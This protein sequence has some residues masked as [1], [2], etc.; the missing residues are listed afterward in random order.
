MFFLELLDPSFRR[1][2]RGGIESAQYKELG[3][4]VAHVQL[5]QIKDRW[6]WTLS[7]NGEFSVKSVRNL[8]DDS[9]LSS[10][11]PPTR[12]V[13][14]IRIKINVFAWKVQKDKL[15]TR[16]NLSQVGIDI[17]SIVCPICEAGVE[18]ADHV[19]FLALWLVKC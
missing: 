18:T 5:V 19:L 6:V 10:N 15:P 12:W 11:L 8:I 7:G 16:F 9:L 4:D 17:Q 2:P 14:E 3:N 13:K 1:M